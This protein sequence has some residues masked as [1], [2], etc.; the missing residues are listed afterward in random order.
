[1]KISLL[2]HSV[3]LGLAVIGASL[4]LPAAA[5]DHGGRHIGGGGNAR[6][7]GA[8]GGGGRAWNGGG[9]GWWGLGLGLGLG[10][11]LEAAY[12][13]YPNYAY[14]YY[15]YVPPTVIIDQSSSPVSPQGTVVVGTP[16][17]S[18]TSYWYYC[19]SAKGYYPYV[20]QCPEP[21]RLVPSVPP[22]PVH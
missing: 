19:D 3:F 22:G 20:P 16:N 8:P 17:S 12:Y 13:G 1:M 6:A 10:L 11:E 21:W 15:P 5:A 14:P 18:P 2:K 9:G 7:H 4:S